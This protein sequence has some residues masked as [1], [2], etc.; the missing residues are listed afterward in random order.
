MILRRWRTGRLNAE[1]ARRME[2]EHE[3][4][5]RLGRARRLVRR[6]VSGGAWEQ[7]RPVEVEEPVRRMRAEAY[8]RDDGGP[9]R[10]GR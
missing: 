2:L 10:K 7:R 5:V 9:Y 6:G 4:T 8:N 1:I 3:E